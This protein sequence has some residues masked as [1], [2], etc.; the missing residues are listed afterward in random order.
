MSQ[1]E[2]SQKKSI[3]AKSIIVGLIVIILLISSAI[4]LF[5]YP[6]ASKEK[7]NYFL[8]D[9]PIILENKQQ[10]NALINDGSVYIPVS[11]IKDFLDESLIFDQKSQ[12]IIITT[13]NK[14]IQMPTKSLTYY[15]NEKPVNLHFPAIQTENGNMYVAIDSLLSYY[16]IRYQTLPET[17]GIWIQQDGEKIQSGFIM[18]KDVHEEK[19]RLRTKPTLQAPYV[20]EV[21][22]NEP[23]FIEGKREDF[24]LI[25]KQNGIA[26]YIKES[27]IKQGDIELVT[28]ENQEKIVKPNPIKGP[29][30]LT[31]EAVYNKNPNTKK[32]PEMP[33]VNVVSPTWFELED[34]DGN[35]N[36]L[37]SLDYVKWAKKRGYQVWGLF[38]NAFDPKLTHLAFKDFE[39][40]SRM[41]RQLLHFSQA[42][43]L[44]GINL[45]IENVS[46]EDGPLIT[47]FVREATPLF[48]E[49]GL[50]VS[51]D[52]T[53]ISSSENWSL[54]YEREK[55]AKIVD[56]LIVMA[57]DEHWGS[58]PIAGSVA[59]LPWVE[60]NTEKLLSVV[61]HQQLILGVPLYTRLWKEE[62]DANGQLK[63]T[64]K[65]LSMGQIKEWLE[66]NKLQPKY[67]TATG[68]N[69]AE[70]FVPDE[71]TTYKVWLEDEVSLKK[72][73]Q[74]AE[75][76]QLA[77]VA[78]WSRFFADDT[79]WT[80]LKF[81]ETKYTNAD[82][83]K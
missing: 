18:D 76:Y 47:Q 34:Q 7:R 40:R 59:S 30:H 19:L 25:R 32:L 11:F 51:I 37:G 71:Q 82:S 10:G 45:D 70:L 21:D 14:V 38:S 67:D 56:Y 12:S 63:V 4:I 27:L 61:P 50:T 49:A 24:Y 42:Y 78:T 2:Y 62:T 8:G 28:I 64:S 16:P 66:N 60:E 53:F 77:G 44:N 5:L 69:Y 9:N 57:Y 36:N 55:L 31:W 54:F 3:S 80:A 15:V 75:K 20:A 52:I 35:I 73:V 33:G 48:H 39:T 65:A 46:L 6:F 26:G 41:I 29:I 17:N 1:L 68:Q 23:V 79:A 13:K 58:S 81:T 43:Q 72:R 83:H 22:S 74:L